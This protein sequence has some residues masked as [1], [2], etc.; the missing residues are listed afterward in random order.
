ML[1]IIFDNPIEQHHPSLSDRGGGV[2]RGAGGG[3]GS[4]DC[5]GVPLVLLTCSVIQSSAV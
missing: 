3:G 2:G 1:Q 5:G 4:A